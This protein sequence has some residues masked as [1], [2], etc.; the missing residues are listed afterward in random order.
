MALSTIMFDYTTG[1]HAFLPRVNSAGGT[2][3]ALRPKP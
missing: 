2:K 1:S 3:K